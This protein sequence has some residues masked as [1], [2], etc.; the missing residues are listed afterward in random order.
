MLYKEE[1]H[2]F[3]EEFIVFI[4]QLQDQICQELEQI[5][6]LAH[7]SKDA[8]DRNPGGRGGGGLTRV[9]SKGHLFEKA[10]VNTSVVYGTITDNMRAQL[11]IEGDQ[12]FACGISIVIHPL[13]PFIPTVHA[14]WRYFELYNQEDQV[15]DR[16]FGGGADLTPYYLY[17]EDAKHFHQCFKQVMD[18]FGTELYPQFKKSCDD[19]F[20]NKHRFNER[21]GVGGI[22]FDQMRP[23][24]KKSAAQLSQFQQAMGNVFLKAYLPIVNKR[25]HLEFGEREIGWQEIR[26]GRYVEFNLIHDK[27]T[28]F[29]L[30]TNG[31][32][33]SILMS[34][35]PRARWEYDYSPEPGTEEDKLMQ[36]CLRP[37]D[38]V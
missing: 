26:R 8:W 25:K 31:R 6:G 21:R 34:L 28:I 30:R 5:D 4:Y 32:T 15:L 37:R 16:W 9:L 27:G 23:D 2:D 19:Y 18:P 1:T 13:N 17:E 38:W 33:E 7:F 22:F 3:R 36:V 10:G 12:W 24:E 20:C 11:N 35:P 14:N 29:G